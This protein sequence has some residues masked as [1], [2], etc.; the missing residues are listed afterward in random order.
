VFCAGSALRLPAQRQELV[1]AGDER[2]ADLFPTA[3]A[4]DGFET[5]FDG[6]PPSAT[7]RSVASFE[8]P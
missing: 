4:A 7:M 5:K 3:T 2:R 1:G 6:T 8:R